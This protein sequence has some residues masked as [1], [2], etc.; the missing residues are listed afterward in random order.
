MRYQL[1][2]LV[3]IAQL[4]ELTD[5]LYEA[6][7][8]PSAIIAADGEI[9]TSS[10]WQRICTEFHRRHPEIERACIESDTRLRDRTAAGDPFV[11]YECP[12]GLV[13]ASSPI[14][15]D[16]E[17]V[18]S[19]FSGQVL[20]A[21]P[22]AAVA[23]RFRD[24]ARA[25]GLDEEAYLAAFRELP[26]VPPEQFRAA[27]RFLARLAEL[28][29]SL[30]LLR[31]RELAASRALQES[32]ARLA[33]IVETVPS[34][35]AIVAA[36]GRITFANAAAEAILRLQRDEITA[37]TYNAP[38]WRITA[39]DGG[40]FPDEDLPVARVLRT[41]ARVEDVVHAI[42]HP[43][44]SRTVLSINAAPLRD[45]LGN[46]SAVVASF[47]DISERTRAERKARE[48]E[49]ELRRLLEL[50]DQSRL[51]LL[52][53]AEDHQRTEAALRESEARYRLIA[54]HASDVIWVLELPE[55]RF[56]YVSPSVERLRGF[57]PEEVMA[58]PLAAALTP[59][60]YGWFLDELARHLE[61]ASAGKLSQR[62]FVR[63]LR[64]PRKDGSLV[65]TE[66]VVTVV[67]DENDKPA[68]LVGV[69]RDITARKA[70]ERALRESEQRYMTL[71]ESAP[72]GIFRTDR[73]GATTYVNPRWC[74][75][76]GMAREEALGWGWLRAV[77]P[78]DRDDLAA[79][80]AQAVK[81]GRESPAEYR[82]V[83]PDGSV[84]WVLGRAVAERDS[85]GAIVGWVGTTTDITERRRAEEELRAA[86]AFQ[87]AVI[88][89]SPLAILSLAADGTVTGWN[90]AA[91]RLFGWRAEEVLGRPLPIVDEGQ[92]EE[93]A[94]LRQRVLAGE[95]L[96][97]VELARRTRDG[98]L[99]DVRLW[100]APVP[101]PG[102]ATVGIMASM[103]DITER[104]AAAA[105]LARRA[106]ELSMVH[107]VGQQLRALMAPQQ[108][109][110]VMIRT[111]E[112]L[113]NYRFG[114]V[115]LLDDA[116]GRLVPFALSDQGRGPEFA[117]R[118]R[119]Y[120]TNAE[121]VKGRGITGWVA[122][123]GESVRVGDV[124]RD[125]RYIPLREE[126]LSELCVPLRIGDTV[127][128]VINVESTELDAF[129][130][131]DQRLLETVADQ[132][133]AAAHNARLFAQVRG[134]AARL[135][136]VEE[137]QRQDIAR[138]LHDR[139]GQTLTALGLNLSVVASALP[140]AARETLAPVLHDAQELV[141]TAAREIRDV[142]AELRPPVLD[143]YGLAA[144]VRFEAERVRRRAG[145]EITV[146]GDDLDPRPP[147]AVETTLFR[148][149]QEALTNVVKHARASRVEVTV[150]RVDGAVRV[151]VADDGVG[152][153]AT[154]PPRRGESGG[155][156][157]LGMRERVEAVGGTV[158]VESTKGSGTRVIIEVGE[159]NARHGPD[160][161]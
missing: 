36:D 139:V 41:G 85:D 109:A 20:A 87:R 72:V 101:D 91:E 83:R 113:L 51:T 141:T 48:S 44:G 151:V 92:Q 34:G 40:P 135:V 59:E 16:G 123:T 2:D 82:L 144:A 128:G 26:V 23:Q 142:M 8:I 31:K 86:E 66:V 38:A 108:L 10:G 11:V 18:A 42:E 100:A 7:G 56:S 75:I 52:S 22:D 116:S 19:V 54:D 35:I 63:E 9:L 104:K 37:R 84:A 80:W 137:R 74:E 161:R 33:A 15:I 47:T 154:L 133:A 32:A 73:E 61:A 93:F 149:V 88:E 119:E 3:D 136:E 21:P 81:E 158:S 90:P 53:I 71:A 45:E 67:T 131:D 49:A 127:I 46:I 96:D 156:G 24:Q 6:T 107:R 39:A 129:T 110:D 105:A 62:T 1:T 112:E 98:R 147:A 50:S 118:D 76:A 94:A 13:D 64:Q 25:F 77:H 4:Q 160:R 79:G 140:E 159:D 150:A 143:D 122:A 58:Q 124:R 99:L 89:S 17:H 148:A 134:L 68:R 65:A 126:V 5:A 29:A 78:D 145:L 120:V 55:L 70:A 130:A 121:I 12:M 115:L 111:M 157:I 155:W 138:E 106:A 28:V 30:G 146:S 125:P 57:T 14:V 132:F 103:E 102:G 117:A 152:F 153:D 95:V 114:A 97:G 60:D 27:L 43:D 69:T